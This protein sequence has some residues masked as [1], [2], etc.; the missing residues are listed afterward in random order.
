MKAG[1][2]FH[3]FLA[4]HDPLVGYRHS[5]IEFAEVASMSMELLTY[6]YL[7]EFYDD[8]VLARASFSEW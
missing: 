4:D 6:P 5:P 3:S 7:G 8:A 1:H 2:A